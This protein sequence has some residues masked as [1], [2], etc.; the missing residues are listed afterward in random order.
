MRPIRTITVPLAAILTAAT[1]T[2]PATAREIDF[3]DHLRNPAGSTSSDLGSPDAQ[4]TPCIGG[5]ART[6]SRPPQ[7]RRSPD[8]RKAAAYRGTFNAPDVAVIEVS[9]SAL[10]G[11]GA[12]EP[13]G[14]V[15]GA[16]TLAPG[17]APQRSQSVSP[18]PQVR[19]EMRAVIVHLY[20]P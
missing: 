15:G 14:V 11:R 20:G 2:T 16:R 10:S 8:A 19:R 17:S 18:S 5:L 13:A 7:T 1:L 3:A 9:S 4:D 6:T 12:V